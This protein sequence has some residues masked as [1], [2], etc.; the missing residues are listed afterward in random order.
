[1]AERWRSDLQLWNQARE[2][3]LHEFSRQVGTWGLTM[4]KIVGVMAAII[5]LPRIFAALQSP[6]KDP[7]AK[8]IILFIA[9][10]LLS[11]PISVLPMASLLYGQMQLL[12]WSM[13]LLICL[14]L[15]KRSYVRMAVILLTIGALI[16]GVMYIRGEGFEQSLRTFT[17][18]S[19]QTALSCPPSD[20]I[21]LVVRGTLIS[22]IAPAETK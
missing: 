6:R 9:W 18:I 11:I 4:P 5:C 17:R 3:V 10:T 21:P 16:D 12:V 14:Q 13:P 20:C 19:A 2:K 7:A 15:T 1:M 8:W 22:M